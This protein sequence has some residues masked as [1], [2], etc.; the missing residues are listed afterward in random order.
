MSGR[1]LLGESDFV[2]EVL[3]ESE[4]QFSR[5]YRLKSRGYDFKRI[6]EKVSKIFQ[7]EKDYITGKGRQQD[8]VMDRD[9]LLGCS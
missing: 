4:A 8:R 9:L 1:C 6:V 3:S 5:R 7:L 2:K